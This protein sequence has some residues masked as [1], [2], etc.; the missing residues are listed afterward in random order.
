M[1]D[2]STWLATYHHAWI[3]RNAEQVAQ[4]FTEDGVY[5]SHPFRSPF[6]GRSEI[7]A[8]WQRAT[9]SQEELEVRWGTPIVSD[10]R[11]AVE[12]WATMRDADEGELTLPGCLLL[13]FSDTG[14]CEELREYWHLEMGSR[15]LPSATWGK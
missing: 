11:A 4:L 14:L 12:W 2:L 13:R 1:L 6:R 3:T 5:H 9:A 10:Q 7:Q 15:V 8:Y